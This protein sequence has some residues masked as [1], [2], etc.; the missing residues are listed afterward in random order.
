MPP[1]MTMNGYGQQIPN[2]SQM[3]DMEEAKQIRQLKLQALKVP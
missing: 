2:M 3:S 1:Y